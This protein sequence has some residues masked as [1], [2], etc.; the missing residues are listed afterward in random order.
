V[1]KEQ[2]TKID[3]HATLLQ[4]VPGRWSSPRVR[5]LLTGARRLSN[6]RHAT[7]YRVFSRAGVS[8]C[9]RSHE[10]GNNLPDAYRR[11]AVY[12]GR[13]LRADKPGGSPI[14]P[15]HEIRA[16]NQSQ[17]RQELALDVPAM[18]LARADEVI[19]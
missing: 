12:V 6:W 10:L 8:R 1:S 5:F 17:D 19:E 4:Q 18:L 13:I 16:G 15:I 2:P 14:E 9:W 3:T 11:N 7:Q